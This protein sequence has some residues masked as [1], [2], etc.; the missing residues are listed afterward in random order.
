MAAI[1]MS[2]VGFNLILIYVYLQLN[3]HLL[4]SIWDEPA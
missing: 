3:L 4:K 1:V 2:E